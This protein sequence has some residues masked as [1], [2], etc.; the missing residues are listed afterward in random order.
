MHLGSP[1]AMLSPHS[2]GV[3]KKAW[4]SSDFLLWYPHQ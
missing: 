2:K 1:W 4:C 3:V